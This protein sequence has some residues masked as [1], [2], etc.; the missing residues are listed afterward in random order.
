MA[1]GRRWS[2]PTRASARARCVPVYNA[3]DPDDASSGAAPE[4]RFAADLVLPRQPAARPRGAG[5]GV[6]PARRARCCPTAASCSAATAGTTRPMPPN[7]APFGH[8]Y[9]HEHNAFNCSPLAV[10]NIA[11]DS[12][13]AIGFS[14][15]TRVFEAAGAGACLITDAW[16]GIELFLD[17]GRGGAGRARRPGCR[18]ARSRA[19][20]P[21]RARADRPRR[22]CARVL[23]EHTYAHRGAEVDALLKREIGEP[24]G[25]HE[26]RGMKLVVLGLSLSSVLGQRPRDHLSR[27]AAAFAARGHDILFLERDVPWYAAQP[28][29][30]RSR[31]LPPRTLRLARG[32]AALAATRSRNADAVIV[33]SYVPEGVAVARWVQR[34]RPRRHR[35]LRHRHAGHAGQARRG[36]TTNISRRE[37]DPRLRPLSLVHRRPDARAARARVRLA[38]A[39]VRSTARSTPTPIPSL[40]VP[41]RWDLSYLGTYSDDRQPTLGTLLLEPARRA[42]ATAASCVAGPQY[43]ADIDWPANVE[44]HRACAAGRAPG[45]LRR[46]P[47][48]PERHARGHGAAGWSARACGCSKPAPAARRSSPTPGTGSTA[49][50]RPGEEIL[51]A[52]A[53]RAGDRHPARLAGRGP[54]CRARACRDRVLADAHGGASR[55]RN[56]RNVSARSRRRQAHHR[57][58]SGRQT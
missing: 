20:T 36:A 12:M 51:L 37:A 29:P 16:E 31:L 11:R 15:A 41:Q 50:F 26:R 40:D 6:L 3:L 56:S 4:P 44:R 13:A 48:H 57:Q 39:R 53:G 14:P 22:R 45:L 38:D 7:V 27:A 42:A 55:A 43:P 34:H 18:G 28:R 35:L 47:L 58:G 2:T 25:R 10:L 46:Q 32:A 24:S 17:A 30:R 9:T 8:V 5:R 52:D 49:L 54:G 33:G 19:L 23:A 1:A 21:E